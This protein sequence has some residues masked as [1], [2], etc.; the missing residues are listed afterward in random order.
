MKKAEVY[1]QLRAWHGYLS[2]FSF[3][4]LIFFS[5][6]GILLNHPGLLRGQVKTDEVVFELTGD[7][8]AAVKRAENPSEA[9]ATIAR[10][11]IDTLGAYR[12]GEE[13]G[14]FIFVRMQ[15][16]RGSTNLTLQGEVP[17]VEA[18]TER[19]STTHMLNTLHRGEHTGAVWRALID[20]FGGLFIV[21]S[22]IGL[23]IFLT[24]RRGIKTAFALI[25]AGSAVLAG[26]FL[27]LVP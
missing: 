24:L 2:A 22:L 3:V 15:S 6:T 17:T 11:H 5:V 27:F 9:L 10:S 12:S 18:V 19:Y 16:A 7:E 25:T 23:A 8:L 4:A 21:L 1:R 13:V 20:V 14:D 26:T